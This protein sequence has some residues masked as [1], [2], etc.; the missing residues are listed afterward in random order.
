MNSCCCFKKKHP[1]G[2]QNRNRLV[3]PWPLVFHPVLIIVY[4]Y[5]YIHYSVLTVQLTVAFSLFYQHILL[6]FSFARVSQDDQKTDKTH[7]MWLIYPTSDGGHRY[8]PAAHC[9]G[10]PITA[11][12]HMIIQLRGFRVSMSLRQYYLESFSDG[13]PCVSNFTKLTIITLTC[14]YGIVFTHINVKLKYFMYILIYS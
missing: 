3:S 10:V 4:L 11:E 2:N 8:W 5:Y 12:I 6:L 1:R 7:C 14:N 13:K 9:S